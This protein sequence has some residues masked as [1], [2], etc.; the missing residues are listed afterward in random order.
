VGR[1]TKEA[2]SFHKSHREMAFHG[3]SDQMS[4]FVTQSS[5]IKIGNSYKLLDEDFKIVTS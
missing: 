2:M 1:N 4:K 5:K 3:V